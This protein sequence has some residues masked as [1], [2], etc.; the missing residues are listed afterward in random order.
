MNAGGGSPYCTV[1]REQGV[2]RI[3]SYVSPLDEYGPLSNEIRLAQGETKELFVQPMQ[4]KTHDLQVD[5]R[6]QVLATSPDAAV[7]DLAPPAESVSMTED[8]RASGMFGREGDRAAER[9]AN[10][11]PEGLPK[12]SAL[13][14]AVKRLPGGAFRS[15]VKME[16]LPPGVYRVTARVFDDTRPGKSE[17]PWVIKDPD[18]LREEWR[19]WTVVTLAAA[20]AAPATPP[21]APPNPPK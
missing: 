5:W 8:D 12:G 2:L 14:A 1:C 7:P 6:L 15:T 19:S 11:L 21:P 17:F 10:P 3:Y 20:A 9:R 16:K 13:K 4:P 18:R